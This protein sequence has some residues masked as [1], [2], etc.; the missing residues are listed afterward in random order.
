[1]VFGVIWLIAVAVI[2][3]NLFALGSK[4]DVFPAIFVIL[5]LLTTV[6]LGN[7]PNTRAV[8]ARLIYS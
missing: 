5:D 6:K 7:D 2:A 1:M 4:Y 3:V 8:R